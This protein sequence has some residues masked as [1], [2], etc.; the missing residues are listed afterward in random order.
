E[1]FEDFSEKFLMW[2]SLARVEQNYD[3]V[4]NKSDRVSAYIFEKPGFS[5]NYSKILPAQAP[6]LEQLPGNSW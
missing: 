2:K 4:S 5:A 3:P 6:A 1:N